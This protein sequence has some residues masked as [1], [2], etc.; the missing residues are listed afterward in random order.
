MLAVLDQCTFT[1]PAWPLQQQ[2]PRWESENLLFSKNKIP[3]RDF[4]FG[5]KKE[6]SP[7]AMGDTSHG[8]GRIP[9]IFTAHSARIFWR[10]LGSENALKCCTS[11]FGCVAL[12]LLSGGPTSV[13]SSESRVPSGD[14]GV[15]VRIQPDNRQHLNVGGSRQDGGMLPP[16]PELEFSSGDSHNAKI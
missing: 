4:L 11:K 15:S 6:Y 12:Q 9:G 8:E 10:C 2:K 5:E 14:G 7:L 3:K 1:L 16:S 13:G